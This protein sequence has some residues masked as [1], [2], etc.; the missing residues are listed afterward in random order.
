MLRYCKIQKRN[1][2]TYLIKKLI[3]IMLNLSLCKRF[4]RPVSNSCKK[5]LME[6]LETQTAQILKENLVKKTPLSILKIKKKR[7]KMSSQIITKGQIC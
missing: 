1:N 6:I 7:K 3:A 2:R 5:F 4:P